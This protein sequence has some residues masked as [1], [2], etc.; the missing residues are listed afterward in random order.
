M[1]LLKAEITNFGSYKH[2][3]FSYEN[4]GLSLIH[5]I[6]GSGKSTLQDVA[7]WILYGI[8]AKNGNSDDIMSW[9]AHHA[10]E[11][12]IWLEVKN[13]EV[14]IYRRRMPPGQNDLYL[15]ENGKI[16]R[17]K[18]ITET[19]KFI[20][21]RLGVSKELYIA[22]A[23]YNEFSPT[24]TFFSAKAKDRRELLE[25][26]TDLTLPIT[27]AERATSER[28][29]AKK[30]ILKATERVNQTSGNLIQLK[31]TK[32]Q[33]ESDS[34]RWSEK[35]AALIEDLKKKGLTF[36]E[37]KKDKL[38]QLHRQANQFELQRAQ[39]INACT[40]ELRTLPSSPSC[41]E[42]GQEVIDVVR[43]RTAIDKFTLEVN[44]YV[45]QIQSLSETLNTYSQKLEDESKRENPYLNQLDR[46][47]KEIPDTESNLKLLKEEQATLEHKVLSLSQIYDMSFTLRGELLKT[48][49]KWVE[50]KTNKHLDTYF[51]SPLRVK[52]DII[53]GDDLEV[54]MSKDGHPCVYRQLSK[55]QRGLLKLC[56]SVAVMEAASNQA[57]VH[58]DTLFFDE[59][60][61]GLDSDL[62]VKAFNLFSE[63]ATKH[64]SV[65]LIDHAQ[66]FQSLF[67][68]KFHVTINGDISSIEEE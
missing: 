16:T 8:T 46:I 22:G 56:F 61:D 27:L 19:Q 17:G 41:P 15:I 50:A 13:L 3:E 29:E 59:A 38:D 28:K 54:E 7:A 58:F 10:T 20:E 9:G 64:S 35:Q 1:K 12:T 18:D 47:N 42:C 60:L 32:G 55:G 24:G 45:R 63:L 66:E 48:S 23:Y 39:K 25:H 43:L 6:T 51:D 36:E 5:G 53:N 11:G 31:R 52:F 14:C 2:L 4:Q 40:D 68:R 49:V 37:D 67:H 21:E 34:Q 30:A 33:I 57:G 65:F 44:P 62:K 26:I